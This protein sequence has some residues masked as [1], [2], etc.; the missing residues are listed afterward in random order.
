VIGTAAITGSSIAGAGFTFSIG[1]APAIGD[2]FRITRNDTG[3]GDNGNVRALV[4]LRAE[5]GSGGTIEANLDTVVTGV[6][7]NLSETNKLAT[8][9]TAVRD[10]AA[11]AADAVSGV[12]L[13][14]EAAELTRLQAAYKANSQV[15]AAAR[16]MFDT[17]LQAV[18]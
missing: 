7:S 17:L 4:A 14:Q 3:V 2:S 1:G 11:R 9:V 12:D 10:D 13:D 8:S 6:A 5:S 16:D 18:R 15:I